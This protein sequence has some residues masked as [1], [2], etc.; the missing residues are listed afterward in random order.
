MRIEYHPDLTARLADIYNTCLNSATGVPPRTAGDWESLFLRKDIDPRAD[1]LIFSLGNNDPTPDGFAWVYVSQFP[2]RV[3][4]R[5]PYVDPEHPE[6]DSI[7]GA[8]IELGMKRASELKA[9]FLETRIIH[10]GWR[11]VEESLGF[12]RMGAYERMRLFPLTGLTREPGIPANTKIRPL[13]GKADILN[14]M[15]IFK[16]VFADHWD[17]HLPKYKDWD[18]VLKSKGTRPENALVIEMDSKVAGYI[19]GHDMPDYISP[20]IQTCYLLSIGIDPDHQ[21]ARF[22]GALLSNWLRACYKSGYRAV[23]LDRDEHNDKAERL[24]KRFGF[25][26]LRTE[27][28]WRKNL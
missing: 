11:S 3:Y 8:L 15:G 23:E 17:F 2:S 26:K 28:V 22:G 10:P 13:S 21:G 18:E 25:K 7:L 6:V 19:L 27:E 16:S 4:L 12:V 9:S 5:G 20:G 14:A 24:Y 1:V